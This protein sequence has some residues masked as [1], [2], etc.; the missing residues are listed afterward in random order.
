MKQRTLLID[1]D[2]LLYKFCYI[3]EF[4]ITWDD[5]TTSEF[6][7]LDR[8]K[9]D[10]DSFVK[11]MLQRTKT[12]GELIAFSSPINFRYSILP[13]YKHNRKDLAKPKMFSDLK[14]YALE[15]YHTKIKEPLEAD[16]VIGILATKYPQKYVIASIDKD[17]KQIPGLHYDWQKDQM[18]E[19]TEEEADRWFFTQ[20]L[21][22]DIGDGYTGC[23][24]IG[25]KKADKIF[26]EDVL[27]GYLELDSKGLNALYW[28]SVVKA[29]EQRGFTE[30][31][32]LIQARVARILRVDDW[33]SEKGEM[34]LWTP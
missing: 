21:I 20:V 32:A 4:P 18:F 9:Q 13:T 27:L 5:E 30:Q 6:I 33:D 31:D 19:V 14:Q 28:A 22:G 16:D 2:I 7:D 26:N 25:K 15:N 12:E 11:Q 8:A 17:L 23:P 24:G 3:N 10:F 1:G 29:Y 34:K